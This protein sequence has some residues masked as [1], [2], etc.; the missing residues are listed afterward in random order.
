MGGRAA[1][2]AGEM[3]LPRR[4]CRAEKEVQDGDAPSIG[5]AHLDVDTPLADT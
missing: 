3:Y 2:A 4:V 1:M 5:A